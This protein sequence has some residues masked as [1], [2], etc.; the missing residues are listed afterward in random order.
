M[1]GLR[2]PANPKKIK[3][4]IKMRMKTKRMLQQ[5]TKQLQRSANPRKVSLSD[6]VAYA[7]E[8]AQLDKV[9]FQDLSE[10]RRRRSE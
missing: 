7:L 8:R 1:G 4:K 10:W 2:L 9:T 5:K 3:V 6:L